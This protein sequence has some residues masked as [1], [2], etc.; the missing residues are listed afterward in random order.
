MAQAFV[1]ALALT[2]HVFRTAKGAITRLAKPARGLPGPPSGLND[3]RFGAGPG[4]PF[5][6]MREEREAGGLP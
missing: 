3:I 1:P 4:V 6:A 5:W 2:P